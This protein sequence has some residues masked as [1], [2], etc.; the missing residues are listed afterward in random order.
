MYQ[1]DKANAP[2]PVV[3]MTDEQGARSFYRQ[4]PLQEG[5]VLYDLSQPKGA[6]KQRLILPDSQLISTKMRESLAVVQDTVSSPQMVSQRVW[7]AELRLAKVMKRAP[8]P[9]LKPADL[10]DESARRWE[11][12]KGILEGIIGSQEQRNPLVR[13]FGIDAIY[14]DHQLRD[15]VFAQESIRVGV[16]K[17][18]LKRKFFRCIRCGGDFAALIPRS[19]EQT[20]AEISRA[21]SETS[22]RVG[23]PDSNELESPGPRTRRGMRQFWRARVCE[24]VI[25]MVFETPSSRNGAIDIEKVMDRLGDRALFWREFRRRF[26]VGPVSPQE[27]DDRPSEF[28]VHYRRRRF[29]QENEAAIRATLAACNAELRGVKRNWPIPGG[30]ELDRYADIIESIQMDATE[31]RSIKIVVVNEG[32]VRRTLGY[33]TIIVACSPSSGAIVAWLVMFGKERSEGYRK[34]LYW[35]ICDKAPLLRWLGLDPSKMKGIVSGAFDEVVVDRGPGFSKMATMYVTGS[36]VMDVTATRPYTAVDKG[37]VEGANGLL[38]N[39]IKKKLEISSKLEANLQKRFAALPI[40]YLSMKRLVARERGSEV[41]GFGTDNSMKTF[42]GAVKKNRCGCIEMEL[43]T[44]NRI[45]ACSVNELNLRNRTDELALSR[46]MILA[47][48]PPTPAEIHRARQEARVADGAKAIDRKT[49]A[50]GVLKC[51]SY[52]VIGGKIRHSSIWY[53]ARPRCD[54]RRHDGVDLLLRDAEKWAAQNPGIDFRI[55]V[56]FPSDPTCLVAKWKRVNENNEI[57]WIDLPATSRSIRTYG[58]EGGEEEAKGIRRR[59][60]KAKRQREITSSFDDGEDEEGVELENFGVGTTQLAVGGLA[61]PSSKEDAYV[62]PPMNS[63][64]IGKEK[65]DLRAY[66]KSI[67]AKLLGSVLK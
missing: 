21:P 40:G 39:R 17:E 12:A 2:F 32:G 16:T 56:V 47:N 60:L 64:G 38:K 15:A 6:R 25:S 22:V 62:P 28:M 3:Q 61:T 59:V 9:R 4:I 11:S 27:I 8:D 19:G 54:D 65:F 51:R 55:D 10:L 36:A 23:A 13:K 44:L 26:Y 30:A 34:C 57:Q 20:P 66:L 31:F 29:V 7:E 35:V 18:E 37:S 67:G 1:Q 63:R 53:G 50:L 14:L 46:S 45:V 5:Y 49:L 48:V 52:K 42:G 41:E 43:P 24:L 33:A 58:E